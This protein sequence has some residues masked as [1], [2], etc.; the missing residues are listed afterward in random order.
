MTN[1]EII[2]KIRIGHGDK[3][4]L[5]LQLYE[6]NR[7]LI[8]KTIR[9]YLRKH[10][11]MAEAD[12]MQ[13]AFFGIVEA[14]DHFNPNKGALFASYMKYWIKAAV[15][16]PFYSMSRTD[17]M[18]EHMVQRLIDYN[19]IL[20]QYRQQNGADP[21]DRV[22][23]TKLHLSQKQLEQLRQFDQRGR[24]LSLSYP[25]PGAEDLTIGDVIPDRSDKINDLCD[26][27]DAERDAAELWAEVDQLDPRQAQAIRTR[28]QGDLSV[29]E[30]ADQM[31]LTPGKVRDAIDRGCRKLARKRT[32]RRIARD[33]G[34][35]SIDLFGGGLQSFLQSGTS[36][37][38]SAV[39]WKLEGNE[40]VDSV[41][42][43][44][45]LH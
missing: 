3:Q 22:L 11:A 7:P 44:K 34:Y 21:S 31:Q 24:V 36:N 23:R 40:T 26:Q 1:E 32:V 6:Q 10:A 2:E 30:V 14:A 19:R 4:Q 38:E 20:T 29:R 8:E 18:P 33:H 43:H 37:V 25:M 28:F 5:L 15:N 9:P 42:D 17:R 41:V 39:I 27:I 16:R 45:Q 35:S 12:L 13:E